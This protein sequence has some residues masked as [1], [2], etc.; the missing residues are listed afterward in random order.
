MKICCFFNNLST[1]REEIYSRIDSAYDCDWYV[2][3]R[4]YKVREFSDDQ[5]RKKPIRLHCKEIKG[6]Y[7]VH[8]LIGLL[9]KDYDVY[10]MVGASRCLSLYFFLT[11]MR[12]FYPKKRAYLWTHGY[13]G[14]EGRFQRVFFGRPLYK[15][16]TG[17]FIYNN[18]SRN[19][20]IQDGIKADKLFTIHNSLAYS[21][22]I[23]L[24]RVV[25]QSNI[26]KEHF[27]NNNPVLIFLGRITSIKRLDLLIDAVKELKSRGETYNVALIGDWEI[28]ASLQQQVVNAELSANVWFYGACY[29]ESRNAELV[30][31]ADL[32]V[33]PG[34][35]GLTA[36]HSLMFG[37][38][39]ITHS[40]FKWQMPEFEAIH[41]NSTGCFFERNNSDDLA[42]KI[43]EWFKANKNRRDEIRRACYKEID[44]SWTPEFQMNVIHSV[45]DNE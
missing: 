41:S 17:A 29:D 45:L 35:I 33:A 38:P 20:M 8:G 21:T 16:C 26:Y 1:Y 40:D 14:K 4:D 32:C 5:L 18:R 36:I 2:E 6:F 43:S 22:Q 30:Y 23:E 12:L 31:N 24:R 39:A 19:L 27:G 10:L 3:D 44:E 37:C 7:I 11:L 13:L 25:N 9:R 34:N 28:N 15:L 42:N